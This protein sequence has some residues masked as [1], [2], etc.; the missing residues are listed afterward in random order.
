MS[1]GSA[2]NNP[3]SLRRSLSALLVN[4]R[5]QVS[6]VSPGVLWTALLDDDEY[7]ALMEKKASLPKT[8]YG[9]WYDPVHVER[10]GGRG[11]VY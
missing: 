10:L 1:G 9:D 5:V 11:K 4:R 6:C 3:P 7:E 2:R 8:H